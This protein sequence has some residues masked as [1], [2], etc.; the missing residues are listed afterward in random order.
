MATMA[1]LRLAESSTADVLVLLYLWRNQF[2]DFLSFR[3]HCNNGG[4]CFLGIGLD[5]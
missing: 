3:L 2:Q 1:S 5:L 4:G